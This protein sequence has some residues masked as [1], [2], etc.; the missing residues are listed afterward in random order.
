MVEYLS[1]EYL[2]I[3]S[4]HLLGNDE[5]FKTWIYLL[6]SKL[7]KITLSF[8][9]RSLIWVLNFGLY[10]SPKLI[11]VPVLSYTFTRVRNVHIKFGIDPRNAPNL[12]FVFVFVFFQG[13]QAFSYVHSD[14]IIFLVFNNGKVL[15]SGKSQSSQVWLQAIKVPSCL[16]IQRPTYFINGT[17]TPEKI[18]LQN[19]LSWES[20]VLLKIFVSYWTTF[21]LSL[22]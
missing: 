2:S 21:F 22:A 3:F 13:K 16:F 20:N 10:F 9:P 8:V 1:C 12:V 17:L 7:D 6:N 11:Q 19:S 18:L 4:L 14:A 5:K 15:S